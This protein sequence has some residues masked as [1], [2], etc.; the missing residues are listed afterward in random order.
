MSLCTG[1]SGSNEVSDWLSKDEFVPILCIRRKSH[2]GSICQASND[3]IKSRAL[4]EM[5]TQY[6]PKNQITRFER[7]T[8]T[9][10][11][12]AIGQDMAWFGEMARRPP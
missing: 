9:K 4:A 6:A 3:R 8:S 12:I 7:M 2:K 10:E 11:K 5:T 1:Y